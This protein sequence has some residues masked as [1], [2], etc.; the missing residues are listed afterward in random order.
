M[1]AAIWKR[2]LAPL[3]VLFLIVF[4]SVFHYRAPY[5]DHWDLIPFYGAMKSGELALHHLFAL[6]G[7]HWHATGYIVQLGLSNLTGMAHWAESLASNAFAGLGFIAL[8]RMVR[9]SAAEISAS[10]AAVWAIAI[11]AFFFFSLDQAA[12][13]LWGWQVAVFINLAAMLWMIERLSTQPISVTNTALAAIA[14]VLA[15]YSFGTGWVLIPIGFALLLLRGDWAE[16]PTQIAL[17]VWGLM[18]ASLL[19]HF[20]LAV[21]DTAAAY[22]QAST[23]NLLDAN[24]WLGL[25][26]Y[27]INFIASPVVR[28]ARDSALLA[29]LLGLGTLLWAITKLRASQPGKVST[30]VLPFL[31][32]AAYSIGAGLLTGFGRWEDFGVQQAFVSR[33]ISFGTPFWISV[34]VL[35]AFA[36]EK[37]QHRSHKR[38]FAV[39][40]LL[41]VLKLANVPSVVQK[42][43]KISGEIA[44]AADH[45]IAAYPEIPPDMHAVLH[46]P[47]QQ[48]E[49]HLETL[50][51]H[52]VSLFRRTSS[53][54]HSEAQAEETAP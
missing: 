38:T 24:T 47:D 51:T 8:V 2:G 35:A 3:S 23:P 6:H 22:T 26:H 30:G 27:T 19:W 10:G 46:S 15:I 41:L 25:S 50:A 32:M 7:N 21:T 29:A 14:C 11:S 34:F 39:L 5:Y 28:F 20:S 17:T 48:I 49:P 12:N 13:W 1:S 54:L 53:D 40:G 18:T 31:A 42:Q 36:I 33:Y 37:T 4:V 52:R 9:H 43:V 16:R 45:I 44:H